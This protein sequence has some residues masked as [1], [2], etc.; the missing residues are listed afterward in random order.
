MLPGNAITTSLH[1]R[2]PLF[3]LSK[4]WNPF[5]GVN[6]HPPHSFYTLRWRWSS[7]NALAANTLPSVVEVIGIEDRISS[8]CKIMPQQ[9]STPLSWCRLSLILSGRVRRIHIERSALESF[10]F[11]TYPGYSTL[12]RWRFV[13]EFRIFEFPAKDMGRYIRVPLEQNI[14]CDI[15]IL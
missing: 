6:L 3:I 9:F 14:T 8:F 12:L 2:L 11:A 1:F 15:Y 4:L 5:S 10:I 13:W 7:R